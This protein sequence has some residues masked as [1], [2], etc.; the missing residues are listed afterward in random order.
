MV[1]PH[2]GPLRLLVM[3]GLLTVT[4][5]QQ[6]CLQESGGDG[7]SG[8]G[9]TGGS[10]GG[11]GGGERLRRTEEDSWQWW[12]RAENAKAA[13]ISVASQAGE[14]VTAAVQGSGW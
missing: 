2:H 9:G 14:K 1:S 7:L 6:R 10:Y 8:D 13:G 11:I 4:W 3:R 12:R 5:E